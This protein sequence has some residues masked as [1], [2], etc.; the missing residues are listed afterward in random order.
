MGIFSTLVAASAVADVVIAQR[1]IPVGFSKPTARLPALHRRG[2]TYSQELNNNLTGGGYYAQVTVGTPPQTVDLIVDTGSSDV[3]ILDSNANLC[4][5]KTM[6]SRYGYCLSTYDSSNS[7]TYSVVS[8]DAFSIRYVDGSGA[9]GDYIKDNFSIGGADIK[10]LQMGL[11][12]NS[13]INSGLLGIGFAANVA[14]ETPYPNIMDLFQNQDLIAIQAYS[15]YLDDLYAATG[16]ILFGGLDTEKFIG[17]LKTVDIQPDRYG[18]YSSFTVTLSS[19]TTTADNGTVANYTTRSA[20]PVILDSGT[21]LTYV[22][23]SIANRIFRAFGAVDDTSGTGLVFISCDYLD[24][25]K[26]LTFDFQFG[27]KDGPVIR[28]PV[29]EM[30]LNNV[31]EYVELGLDVPSMPFDNVCSFGLQPNSDYYLLGDTFLR[32]AYVVYDLTNKQ[33]GLAQA[34]LN[35]TKSNILEI[36]QE[37]GIPDASG[38]ASQVTAEQTATGLPGTGNSNGGQSATTTGSSSTPSGQSSGNAG[39]RAVSAPS[40]EALAVTAITGLFG[41]M[42]VGLV[43]L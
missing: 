11:A 22:P 41:L 3:W 40:W 8:Q 2:G 4:H 26:N 32:S 14:A 28:V 21:T 29:D 23:S 43:V 33:I 10:A 39:A 15:L 24:D 16:T 19:L 13:T 42:G 6:Q 17:E 31:Q 38:V 5:S 30:V 1:V 34:N 7:S 27:G 12:E 9:E 35:S 18:N 20:V 25:N 36:T 37:S